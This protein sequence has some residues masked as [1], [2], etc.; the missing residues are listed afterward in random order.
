MNGAAA[1]PDAPALTAARLVVTFGL[2]ALGPELLS[3][4]VLA[5]VEVA[6]G[7]PRHE[8]FMACL[9]VTALAIGAFACWQPAAAFRPARPGLVL[10]TYVPLFVA[11][12][13]FLVGYL[14][15]MHALGAPVAAQ[16]ALDYFAVTDPRHHGFWIVAA[17]TTLGAPL[18]EEVIFRGYLHALLRTWLGPWPTIVASACAFGFVHGSAYALPIGLLGLYFAWLRE[19]TGSLAPSLLAHS[20][21]NGIAVLVTSCWPQHLDLLYPR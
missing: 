15:V 12:A 4:A 10:R 3:R 14:R 13:L 8:L 20:M 11:W 7:W 19:R 18:A 5:S 16:R 6:P 21:H 1:A 17:A 9:L 2:L